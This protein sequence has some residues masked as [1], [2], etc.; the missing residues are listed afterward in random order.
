M[1][2]L[3]GGPVGPGDR[4]NRTNHTMTLRSCT[5]DGVVLR[6]EHP[7]AILDTEFR[8]S[9][10]PSSDTL[11]WSAFSS[12][13]VV[14]TTSSAA[15]ASRAGHHVVFVSGS[16]PVVIRPSDLLPV[17]GTTIIASRRCGEV[18]PTTSYIAVVITETGGVWPAAA[19]SSQTITIVTETSPLSLSAPP[20]PPGSK[21]VVPFV[22]VA[23]APWQ[24]GHSCGGW[25]VL[26]E[27]D[28]AVPISPNRFGTLTSAGTWELVGA[29]GEKVW[30]T[31]VRDGDVSTL[32]T[33][34][35]ILSSEGAGTLTCGIASG[36]SC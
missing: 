13:Q 20:V 29:P 24:S 28:K 4:L 5:A 34:A 11:A 7:L 14:D 18:T 9:S 16:D 26:G 1:A 35:C 8:A 22:Y 19:T 31:A 3:S 21:G 25:V 36:C 27:L 33:Q 23:L 30:L 17:C 6:P 15:A 32:Y 2:T 12:F 10:S